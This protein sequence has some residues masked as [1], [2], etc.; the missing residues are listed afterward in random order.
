MDELFAKLSCI[1]Q[2]L[3]FDFLKCNI[4]F[5]HLYCKTSVL[6]YCYSSINTV[7]LQ[8]IYTACN[9]YCAISEFYIFRA[10]MIFCLVPINFHLAFDINFFF[11]SSAEGY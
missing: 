8:C 11:N 2:F 7:V 9:R 10:I 5:W 1:V 4:I 6:M 3:N